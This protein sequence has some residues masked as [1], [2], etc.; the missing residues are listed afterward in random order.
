MGK[1]SSQPHRALP[2]DA[3][4]TARIFYDTDLRA[5]L[6]YDYWKHRVAKQYTFENRAKIVTIILE[7]D[8]ISVEK[9]KQTAENLKAAIQGGSLRCHTTVPTELSNELT[10]E[11][12]AKRRRK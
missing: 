11:R 4:S 10:A 3:S 12:V 1:E 6:A 8:A 2:A 5:W 9:R 7:F